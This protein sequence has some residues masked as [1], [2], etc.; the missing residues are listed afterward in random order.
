MPVKNRQEK[1]PQG[2]GIKA[3]QRLRTERQ[4]LEAI[5]EFKQKKG[6]S[7][8][9]LEIAGMTGINEGYL[10]RVVRELRRRGN[11]KRDKQGRLSVAKLPEAISA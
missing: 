3:Q 2:P 7:P 9:Q 5:L 11:V 6:E 1:G 10:S 4:I 8:I